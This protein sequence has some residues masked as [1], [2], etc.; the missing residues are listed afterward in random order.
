MMNITVLLQSFLYPR[1]EYHLYVR[2]DTHSNTLCR[3][4]VL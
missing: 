3:W 1:S 2:S 4:L